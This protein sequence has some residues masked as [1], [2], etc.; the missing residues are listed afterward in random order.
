[1]SG[2]DLLAQGHG[3]QVRGLDLGGVVHARGDAVGDQVQQE[4]F[5]ALGGALQQFDQ[6]GGLRC[7]QGKRGTPSA[8]R[9]AT[10]WR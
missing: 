9:S 3:G 5:L 6:L 2:H 7:R 10:C 1:M 8:A 4:G